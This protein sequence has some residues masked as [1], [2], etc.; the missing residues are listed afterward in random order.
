MMTKR[1]VCTHRT[2]PPRAPGLLPHFPYLLPISLG[3]PHPG[4]SPPQ[5]RLPAPHPAPPPTHCKPAQSTQRAFSQPRRLEPMNFEGNPVLSPASISEKTRKQ[6]GPGRRAAA[7]GPWPVWVSTNS[8]L[9]APENKCNVYLVS[10][11]QMFKI[12]PRKSL[13]RAR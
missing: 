4:V 1:T 2:F 8:S 10:L 3:I 9:A 6:R 5:A 11:V 13:S 7:S 12:N